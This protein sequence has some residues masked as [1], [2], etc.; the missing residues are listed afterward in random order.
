MIN[1]YIYI[2]KEYKITKLRHGIKKKIKLT[3]YFGPFPHL[4]ITRNNIIH[5]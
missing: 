4:Y 2:P 1:I 5:K 3:V